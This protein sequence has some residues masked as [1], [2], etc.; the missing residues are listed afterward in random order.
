[1]KESECSLNEHNE[2]NKYVCDDGGWYR[3]EQRIMREK[4]RILKKRT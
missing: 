4:A 1:M 3:N 2:N